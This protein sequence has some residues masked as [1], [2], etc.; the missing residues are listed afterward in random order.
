MFKYIFFVSEFSKK[1]KIFKIG[2]KNML[3]NTE[4]RPQNTENRPQI[5]ENRPQNTEN[6]PQNTGNK[7]Q[8]TAYLSY[9]LLSIFLSI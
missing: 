7:P 6:R 3:Q 5:T 4:N 2:T 1:N 8:K 9:Y